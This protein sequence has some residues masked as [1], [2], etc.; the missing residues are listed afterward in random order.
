M[1]WLHKIRDGYRRMHPFAHTAFRIAFHLAL[2]L[3]LFAA[4]AHLLA[5]YTPDY[6]R[7][8][9]YRDAALDTAPVL[10]AAGI[11]GGLVGDLVLRRKS[12][13]ETSKNN[14]RPKK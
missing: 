9:A 12:D 2:L 11:I 4:A 7:T 8:L 3:V 10:F 5:P 6:L 1:T 13:D 14:R